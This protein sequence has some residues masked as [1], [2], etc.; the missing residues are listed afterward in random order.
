LTAFSLFAGQA[1]S[2]VADDAPASKPTHPHKQSVQPQ[3]PTQPVLPPPSKASLGFYQAAM[4]VNYDMMDVYLH[5]GADINCLNCDPNYQLTALYRALAING[6]WNFQ[7]AD[8]LI[9]HGADINIPTTT[10]QATG[11]TIVMAAAG[12]SNIPNYQALNKLVKRGADVKAVDSSGRTALHYIREW[13]WIDNKDAGNNTSREFIAFVDTLVKNGIDVNKQD[14]SGATAL[15]NAT[16]YCSPGAVNLL[17]SYGANPEIKNKLGKSPLD[18][19]MERAT[20]VGQNS[21]CNEVVKML[22]NPQQMSQ[23]PMP[24]NQAQHWAS[25][26]AGTYGGSFTGND[27]GVFQAVIQQDGSATLSGHSNH[28]GVTFTGVGKVNRDGSIE[29]GSSSTGATFNGTVTL[30]GGLAGGWKNTNQTGFFQGSKGALVT[31]PPT[32][33]LKAIGSIL[34]SFIKH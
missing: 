10:V 22:M 19:A 31:V 5:Q 20:S 24:G 9:Q 7:L 29:M 2:Q 25:G 8:W 26:F 1:Y 23:S 16:N 33:P 32:D 21:R 34:G 4:N 3:V 18:I 27:E 15:M 12:Y 14:N 6:A 11:Y 17:V 13:N 28:T 30:D